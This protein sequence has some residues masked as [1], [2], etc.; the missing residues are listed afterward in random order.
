MSFWF[1]LIICTQPAVWHNKYFPTSPV[2]AR[3]VHISFGISTQSCQTITGLIIKPKQQARQSG[4]LWCV[5][6]RL[7]PP[8]S[9]NSSQSQRESVAHWHNCCTAKTNPNSCATESGMTGGVDAA[10]RP[11]SHGAAADRDRALC[12]ARLCACAPCHPDCKQELQNGA[13]AASNRLITAPWMHLYEPDGRGRVA[14]AVNL[15]GNLF[16]AVLAVHL[17]GVATQ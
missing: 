16:I 8:P 9:I 5:Q 1:S 13:T 14:S 12:A 10:W 17:P 15:R 3:Q 4:Q 11:R 7:A 2:V 6:S